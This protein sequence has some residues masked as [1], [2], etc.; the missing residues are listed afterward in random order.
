MTEAELAKI[1]VQYESLVWTVVSGILKNRRDCEEAS[2]DVFI[3]LWRSSFA[4]DAVGA[5]SYVITLAKRRAVDRLRAECRE[6]SQPLDTDSDES[7]DADTSILELEVSDKINSQ[8][9]AEVIT[10]LPPPDAE[11]FTRRYYYSQTV[12]D[13]AHAMKLKP[14]YVK[15]RLER[16]K[17]GIRE[18]MIARGLII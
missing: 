2:A 10:S 11:I 6:Q 14:L 15:S 9:I 16:A 4:P 1:M 13:I 3:S 8:I 5:K 18:R 12:K 17:A 7:I